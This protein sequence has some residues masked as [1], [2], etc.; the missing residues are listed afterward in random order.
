MLACGPSQKCTLT[1]QLTQNPNEPVRRR[2]IGKF[3]FADRAESFDDH[4]DRSILHV[5]TAA[6]GE[7]PDLRAIIH[8]VFSEASGHG[9][10][11]RAASRRRLSSSRLIEV[12][13]LSGRT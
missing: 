4:I 13:E 9:L 10:S 12:I 7:H 11:G 6:I 2:A 3:D 8:L 1:T 5:Q